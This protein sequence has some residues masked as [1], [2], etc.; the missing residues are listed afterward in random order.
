[1]LH[2]SERLILHPALVCVSFIKLEATDLAIDPSESVN[3]TL[4]LGRS[5]SAL[6]LVALSPSTFSLSSRAFQTPFARIR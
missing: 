5:S 1:M 2:D 6:L 3:H 4:S